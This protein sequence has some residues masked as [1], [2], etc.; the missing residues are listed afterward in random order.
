MTQKKTEIRL[1]RLE[2]LT[3]LLKSQPH[4]IAPE[5]AQELGISQRTLMRDLN[6]LKNKG[7]PIETEQ[8]RGGGIRLHPHWGMG[9]LHLNYQE[10]IDLLLSLAIMEKVGSSLFL[11]HLDAIKDK[12]ASA[13]PPEQ[14]SQ[15]QDLRKRIL[16][17][18]CT[19]EQKIDRN[20]TPISD[21]ISA[22]FFGQ[23]MVDITYRDEHLN[24]TTRKIEPHYLFL[25]W[26]IWY[27]LAYDHLR[28]DVRCFRLD[29]IQSA[30]VTN[31]NF[32]L[33]NK[34]GFT[35]EIASFSN[36]L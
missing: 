30:T 9:K 36:T 25:N 8:G 17:S 28:K 35:D 6:I 24:Q 32:T 23:K 33:K 11:Q 12:I 15:I 19:S 21:H 1:E 3:G 5:L 13:F 2:R 27:I 16:I 31:Q 4:H 18:D 22:G 14:R 7:Y 26:P 20:I 10:L 29:R 34:S